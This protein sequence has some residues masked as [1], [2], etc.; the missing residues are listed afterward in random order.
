MNNVQ[1]NCHKCSKMFSN[2]QQLAQHSQNC[3][4]D[5]KVD[6]EGE[7]QALDP[8]RM[9]ISQELEGL[10]PLAAAEDDSIAADEEMSLDTT[11]QETKDMLA[12][13][14]EFIKIN[15]LD[16]SDEL[17]EKVQM[18]EKQV[19]DIKALESTEIMDEDNTSSESI[20]IPDEEE[21]LC[22]KEMRTTKLKTPLELRPSL[23]QGFKAPKP[24]PPMSK[25]ELRR[26]Q[27]RG[28]IPFLPQ[29]CVYCG[30][31]CHDRIS[32]ARH[33]IA[34]HWQLVR[35][36]QGGGRKDNSA[37]YSN[38]EDSRTIKPSNRVGSVA[39]SN[40]M[41]GSSN[42][43]NGLP[44]YVNMNNSN[45]SWMKKLAP[46]PAGGALSVGSIYDQ[47]NKNSALNKKKTRP[48]VHNPSWYGKA[49]NRKV[50]APTFTMSYD[51]TKD[52][53]DACEVCDDDFNWPDANHKCK[54]TMKK[55]AGGKSLVPIAPRDPLYVKSLAGG[56]KK[57]PESKTY[58]ISNPSTF[59]AGVQ[60]RP[61]SGGTAFKKIESMI[62][63]KKT[64]SSDM[65]KNLQKLAS[66]EKNNRKVLQPVVS[67]RSQQS[68]GGQNSRNLASTSPITNPIKET[69]KAD[70]KKL[71]TKKMSDSTG[72]E[73]VPVMKKV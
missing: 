9:A 34:E 5:E 59:P 42:V 23:S 24:P 62:Q 36:A 72:L 47:V 64:T 26:K 10:D 40:T 44:R 73:I 61:K 49:P 19:S 29:Q 41:R 39:S 1:V 46:A 16:T 52:D 21:E 65:F 18:S 51:L 12:G 69:A 2:S 4:K 66:L 14:Q 11:E 20:V 32:L 31:H 6:A 67:N 50:P 7:S 38:I 57:L 60:M 28:E 33:M 27:I 13:L 48:S 63:P 43:G 30:R 55:E 70:F 45:P 15:D 22:V 54:K 58:K 3:P 71:L 53:D 25:K 56:L 37:Y 35:E 68:V 17:E 8:L